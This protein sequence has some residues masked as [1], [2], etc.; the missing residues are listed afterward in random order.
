MKPILIL[1]LSLC[2][3]TSFS[4]VSSTWR[5]NTPGREKDWNTS[6]NW[7]NNSLPDQFTDVIIPVDISVTYSYP[8]INDDVEINSLSIWPGACLTIKNGSLTIYDP[9]RSNYKKVQVLG[10]KN[11]VEIDAALYTTGEVSNPRLD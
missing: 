3:L 6:S 1:L 8:V 2:S 10:K 4:Q 9:E 5:G 11:L 7:S